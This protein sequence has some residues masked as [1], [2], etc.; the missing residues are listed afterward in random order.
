MA[1]K[2]G[3]RRKKK[4]APEPRGLEATRLT[5]GSAPAAVERLSREI[6][7]DGGSVLGAYR[8]PLGGHWQ[9]LAGLPLERVEPTPYQRD[10]SEAHVA[11]LS[12]A[13][14]RLGRFL[15]PVIAVRTGEGRYWTPNGHHRVAALKGLGATS[16]VALVVPEPEVARRILLLNTERAHNL[17]E[18]ALEV[19]R[20]A[21]GL[22]QLDDRAE[23]EFEAEFEEPSLLT[24]GLCYQ[25]N[26]RF[27]GGV[28]HSVLKRVEAFLPARLTRAL[29]TRRERARKLLELNAQVD[30][31]MARLKE[32]GFQSPYLRAFVVARINP[33]RFRRGAKAEFDETIEQMMA[34]AKKFD[35]GK[36]KADQLAAAGGPPEE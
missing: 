22:A 34:A 28:Y 24:L 33:L 13:I 29:E 25:E 35:A 12:D 32:K 30:A 9:V 7:Q 4:T 15:D 17:R 23:R 14:D 1:T 6:E 11:R 18:R 2:R 21:Q 20:L 36:V 26:G 31:A 10:L 27:S 16:I 5:S 19:I 3:T 8:D